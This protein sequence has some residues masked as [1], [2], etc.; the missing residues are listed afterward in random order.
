MTL[1]PLPRKALAKTKSALPFPYRE[2]ASQQ[3]EKGE[4]DRLQQLEQMLSGN[5]ERAA[6]MERKAYD[7]AYA[8]GEKAGLALGKKR[9]EQI[10]D[11]MQHVLGA[12]KSQIDEIRGAACESII[13]ISGAIS[14]W[15][16]GEITENERGRL[17]EMATK[18]AC[19]MPE[20][21]DM[22]IAVHPDVFTQFE[23]LLHESDS[24]HPLIADARVAPGCI[25]I[26]NKT[27]DALIDPATSIADGI[28]YIK[29]ELLP[30]ASIHETRHS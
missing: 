7:K 20:M 18:T 15:L 27:Q 1:D 21:H 24:P 10:L 26:F 19:K 29:S 13:D 2:F 17:L 6:E 22:K 14:E 25:R 8:S 3:M 11:Q 28:A 23:K 5:Q 30:D 4:P 12:A 16:I 9:A